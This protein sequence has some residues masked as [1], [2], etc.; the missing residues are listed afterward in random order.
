M[1][2]DM[3]KREVLRLHQFTNQ[4]MLYIYVLNP[5]VS[6]GIFKNIYATCVVTTHRHSALLNPIVTQHLLPPKQLSVAASHWYVLC[7]D[8][9][10]G[11]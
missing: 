7:L 11:Y 1:S 4:L 8:H 5:R 3:I 9:R 10:Q 2:V 6:N